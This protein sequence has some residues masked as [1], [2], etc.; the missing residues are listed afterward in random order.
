VVTHIELLV[1]LG[2]FLIQWATALAILAAL[3]A[4]VGAVSIPMP[5]FR[6]SPPPKQ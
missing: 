3:A 2:G 4:F 1:V 5:T 6:R